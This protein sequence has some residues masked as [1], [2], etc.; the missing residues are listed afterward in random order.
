MD[1]RDEIYDIVLTLSERG[2]Q[3]LLAE[4]ERMTEEDSD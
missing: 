4:L 1:I 3:W 2:A